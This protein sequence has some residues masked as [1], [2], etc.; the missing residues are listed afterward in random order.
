[1]FSNSIDLLEELDKVSKISTLHEDVDKVMTDFAQRITNALNIERMSVWFF[2]N[3]CTQVVSIAEFDNRT[4]EFKKGTVLK[5]SDFPAYFEAA[6]NNKI[7][8]APNILTNPCTFQFKDVYSIP[9][10]IISLMDIPLRI[11]GELKGVMC[12]EKTGKVERVFSV[13]EQTLAF[14]ISLVFA[15]NLEARYRK[16]AQRKLEDSLREKEHLINEIHH[17][18]KNNFSILISLLR[19][20]RMQEGTHNVDDILSD[21][22]KRVFSMLK[23]Q[24]LL[25][26][27]SN[28]V[29]V[30]ISE[31]LNELIAEFKSSNS[32]L[33][34]LI[35]KEITDLNL[36]VPSKYAINVGLLVTEVLLNALK[37]SH[38]DKA[39][40]RINFSFV[41]LAD[42]RLRIS[43]ADNGIGFDFDSPL[44]ENSFGVSIIKDLSTSIFETCNYPK[45][46]NPKYDFYFSNSF[47]SSN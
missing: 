38:L 39:K 6:K 31:Y 33:P 30:N 28:H 37:H 3:N 12:F 46:N 22:E 23:I 5:Q 11:E 20:C 8:L 14:S 19:L 21:F 42:G 13:N 25:F 29:S 47:N 34:N 43:I 24:D 1:M 17:R 18:V 32:S 16:A 4:N 7:L 15:S 41:Q 45:L 10:D 35:S 27:S 2:E 9:N 36:L 40:T 44:L 26:E